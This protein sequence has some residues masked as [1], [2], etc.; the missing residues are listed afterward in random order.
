MIHAGS[1]SEGTH[2]PQVG[3]PRV[4]LESVS[5]LYDV[6]FDERNHEMTVLC[7]AGEP[8]MLLGLIRDDVVN[9]QFVGYL[10]K[11]AT[12]TKI[13]RD[14]FVQGDRYFVTGKHILEIML[15]VPY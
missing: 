5:Q 10:D 14:V 6:L 1:W 12:E 3:N 13:W 8:G 2:D 4:S 11:K 15:Q 7:V 9:Q